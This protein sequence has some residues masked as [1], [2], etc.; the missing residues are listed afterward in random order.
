[1][2]DWDS[3]LEKN[4]TVLAHYEAPNLEAL[5]NRNEKFNK[6]AGKLAVGMG[7][8]AASAQNKPRLGENPDDAFQRERAQIKKLQE[9]QATREN[10]VKQH[11][12]EQSAVGDTFVIT[13]KRAFIFDSALG[14]ISWEVLFDADLLKRIFEEKSEKVSQTKNDVSE[15]M[16]NKGFLEK[17]RYGSSQEYKDKLE[18]MYVAQRDSIFVLRGIKKEKSLLKGEKIIIDSTAYFPREDKNLE[19]AYKEDRPFSL[20]F[21]SSVQDLDSIVNALAPF[22]AKLNST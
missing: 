6:V 1:M 17:M 5:E 18:A 8:A 14:S 15:S 19:K 3:V 13:N 9:Q 21:G 7:A 12:G 4:E 20:T 10:M 22:S 2:A 16:K 11:L